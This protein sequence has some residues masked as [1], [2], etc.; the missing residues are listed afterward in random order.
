MK[1][2]AATA[3]NMERAFRAYAEAG[4][5]NVKE[6][7]KRLEAEFG[8]KI[9]ARTLY[10]WKRDG[11]WHRRMGRAASVHED[12]L[13]RLSRMINKFE[14]E[15]E[16]KG[17]ADPQTVY[18]Y[19]NMLKAACELSRKCP[20]GFDPKETGQEAREIL[21]VDYGLRLLDMAEEEVRTPRA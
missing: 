14:R 17:K 9:S 6:I 2:G 15:M 1:K 12:M 4:G 5:R 8:L 13:I 11:D 19:V 21:N 7:L 16:I 20:R 18:A 10:E 3:E